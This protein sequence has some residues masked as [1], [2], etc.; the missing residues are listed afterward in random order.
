MG[1][2]YLAEHALIG[3]TRR[4]QGAAARA[5]AQPG[6]RRA[7]LQRG[8]RDRV[9][10]PPGHRPDLRLR[11]PRRRQRLHRDGAARGRVAR[12]SRSRASAASAATPTA[13]PRSRGRSPARSPPRTPR[14]SSIAISSPTTSSCVAAD[15]EAPA[16]SVQDPRLRHRQAARRR[17]ARRSRTTRTGSVMGTPIVHVARAVPRR[18]ARRPPH[19]H[20]LARLH[21]LR[22][23]R[24]PAAVRARRA[25]RAHLAHISEPPPELASLVPS[26]PPAL[27]ALVARMLVKDPGQRTQTME[28]VVSSIES[29]LRVPS[30]QFAT[31]VTAPSGFPT[32]GEAEPAPALVP[33][34][35]AR[36]RTVAAH[37]AAGAA[38]S[39][40]GAAQPGHYAEPRRG[41]RARPAAAATRVADRL[42]DRSRRQRSR[43][44]GSGA[45]HFLAP[46]RAPDERTRADAT[47]RRISCAR[48]RD[49]QC[50]LRRPTKSFATIELEGAPNGLSVTLDGKPTAVPV[51]VPAGPAIHDLRF[52]A[53]GFEP[54]DIKVAGDRDR[55]IV[56]DMTPVAV[57]GACGSQASR[58]ADDAHGAENPARSRQI[59]AG[60][61]AR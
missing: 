25:R 56:L 57:A 11:R 26:V 55:S 29:L 4:D 60:A 53:A 59:A 39:D 15:P 45:V 28:E 38:G 50:V 17:R 31:R 12:R 30:S 7:L 14:G 43:G 49:C 22:A 3:R 46:S 36:R 35:T 20:L 10:P 24:R 18:G 54:R 51:A 13:L 48:E 44:G 27:A 9:D 21:P 47:R 6:H 40:Q 2:V 34:P 8:A 23:A 5:V 58:S 61:G 42:Q 1:A 16:A 52:E 19:R 32:A 33:I 37:V 41:R